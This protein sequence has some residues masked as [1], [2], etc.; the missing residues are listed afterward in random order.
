MIR[1]RSISVVCLSLLAVFAA[2]AASGPFGPAKQVSPSLRQWSVYGSRVGLDFGPAGTGIAVWNDSNPATSA[3]DRIFGQRLQADGTPTGTPYVINA[4]DIDP[5]EDASVGIDAQGNSVVVWKRTLATG[6]SSVRARRFN[7]AGQALGNEFVV[8]SHVA[9]EH[10]DPAIVV[11]PD[12]QFVVAW[13]SGVQDGFGD[14]FIR[15]FSAIGVPQAPEVMANA[16]T[17][18]DQVNPAIALSADGGFVVAWEGNGIRLGKDIAYRVFDSA[19]NAVSDEVLVN[20]EFYT[21]DQRN[22]TIARNA[23]GLTAIAWDCYACDTDDWGI[24]ARLFNAVGEPVTGEFVVNQ[25][26]ADNQVSAAAAVDADGKVL[27]VWSSEHASESRSTIDGRYFEGDGTP[28]TSEF[29]VT[30]EPPSPLST[31]LQVNPVVRI[32]PQGLH[33]AAWAAYGAQTS[34]TGIYQARAYAVDAGPNQHIS[35]HKPV[36]ELKGSTNAGAP[37]L[38]WQWSQLAGPPVTLQDAVQPTAMFVTPFETTTLTFLLSVRYT[39]GT[40]TED[41]TI[42]HIDVDSPQ[43]D[44]GQDQVMAE[45]ELVQLGGSGTAH[46]GG[47]IASFHWLQTSGPSVVLADPSAAITSFI[48]P[49]VNGSA[50]VTLRLSVT[51]DAGQ[52]ATDDVDILVLNVNQ[53]PVADFSFSANNLTVGFVDASS[54]PDGTITSRAWNFGDFRATAETNPYH[55]YTSAGTYAVTLTITDN[56]GETRQVTRNVTVTAPP[57]NLPPAANFTFSTSNASASFVDSSSDPDG[58]IASRRWDFGDGTSSTATNPIRTYA[59]AGTYAVTLTVTDNRGA[60]A[61]VVRN[62]TV[63]SN[64]PPENQLQNGVPKAN[65]SG[66]TSSERYFTMVVPPGAYGLSF[67]ISGGTGDADLYVRFGSAPTTSVY[68]CRPYISGNAETCNISMVRAGTYH[69]MIR[70]YSS[71]AGLQLVGRYLTTP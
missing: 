42:V 17:G 25:H 65:L 50:V 18:Y 19:G 4:S 61:Q 47:S 68:E 48:A 30:Q 28:I 1:K 29:R 8:H 51:D 15:R 41:Q 37:I 33:R 43:A 26:I 27:L 20:N 63:T 66:T 22:P 10:Y 67:Q 34:Q 7:A 16:Y 39:D 71:Y 40:Q 46:N 57:P 38:D 62:V 31:R 12:G 11:R 9:S 23:S 54:D 45:G 56:D 13:S 32:D 55:T 58:T 36:V 6:R 44:A 59:T 53:A 49:Q 35:A 21:G 5:V 3:S 64:P 52:T 24:R 60:S 69:V 14:I 2:E 70:G